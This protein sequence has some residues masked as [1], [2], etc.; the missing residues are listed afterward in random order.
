[1][2]KVCVTLFSVGLSVFLLTASMSQR[3]FAEEQ[4]REFTIQFS[5]NAGFTLIQVKNN[6]SQLVITSRN[7]EDVFDGEVKLV[8]LPAAAKTSGVPLKKS[9]Q[10]VPTDF[11]NI[12]FFI[13]DNQLIHYKVDGDS[14]SLHSAILP[15]FKNLGSQAVFRAFYPATENIPSVLTVRDVENA[16]VGTYIYH[17]RKFFRVPGK[18]ID[19]DSPDQIPTKLKAPEKSQVAVLHLKNGE[20]LSPDRIPLKVNDNYDVDQL[21]SDPRLQSITM[22][23]NRDRIS[24]LEFL[25]KQFTFIRKSTAFPEDYESLNEEIQKSLRAL[26]MKNG[27]SVAVLGRPGTG[28]TYFS[29]VLVSYIIAGKGPKEL[30]K[31]IYIKLSNGDIAADIGVVGVFEMKVKALKLLASIVPVTLLIDEMHTLVGAGSHRDN[32][33]DFYQLLK[34]DLARGSIKIIGTTTDNEWD[35]FFAG[36]QAFTER[37]PIKIKIAEPPLAKTVQILE[38][39]RKRFYGNNELSVSPQALQ[40]IA[41]TASRFDPIGANPRKS[42]RLAEYVFASMIVENKKEIGILDVSNYASQLYGFDLTKYMPEKIASNLSSLRSQVDKDLVGLDKTKDIIEL[43]LGEHFFK[44]LVKEESRPTG[45]LIYGKRGVGKTVFSQ[46]IAKGLNFQYNR[47]MMSQFSHPGDVKEFK[48]KLGLIIRANPFSVVLFDEIEKAHPAVQQ[49]LL[50]VMD[51][52]RFEA[53]LSKIDMHSNTTEIDAS[54]VI[55]IAATNAAQSLADREHS[56]SEFERE[57][58]NDGLNRYLLDR[59]TTITA[60][61]SPDRDAVR[62][63]LANKWVKLTQEFEKTGRSVDVD[64]NALIAYVEA[65]V[66]SQNTSGPGIGFGSSA[67]EEVQDISVRSLERELLKVS[68]QLSLYFFKNSQEQ[69]AQIVIERGKL[70]IGAPG[71]ASQSALALQRSLKCEGAF[72]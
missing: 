69:K 23:D 59:F 10:V 31:R 49:S 14:V 46:T 56:F 40:A 19:L 37:F 62:E 43:A 68:Q 58:L 60:L 21:L 72:L 27:G 44:Q 30:Q 13:V 16:V 3:V 6:G 67:S 4:K 26:V 18:V 52:G 2:K 57:A 47:I 53:S 66:K 17:H 33:N 63:I 38:L 29:D 22:P 7:G 9:Y 28:K 64:V 15:E 54:K 20:Y 34:E 41:L 61:K 25:Q 8:S 35:K 70:I 36:D 24:L 71:Q 55:F 45:I 5:E 39:F 11:I 42:L 51:S 32:R 1:M 48:S 12:G 65:S 50:D